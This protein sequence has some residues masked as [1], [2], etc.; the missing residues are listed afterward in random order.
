MQLRPIIISLYQRPE[1]RIRNIYVQKLVNKPDFKTTI[2]GKLIHVPK[3][4]MLQTKNQIWMR[5]KNQKHM[6]VRKIGKIE[7]T[8]EANLQ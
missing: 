2:N 3:K 5:K 1:Y 8:Q 6:S 7:I 4:D